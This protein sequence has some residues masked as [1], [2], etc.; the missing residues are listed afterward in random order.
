MAAEVS[1]SARQQ[2]GERNK[3]SGRIEQATYVELPSND[4]A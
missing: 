4:S 3:A 2:Q 1:R